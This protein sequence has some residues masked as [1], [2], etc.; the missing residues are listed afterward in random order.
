MSMFLMLYSPPRA[1]IPKKWPPN[2]WQVYH[3]YSG[4][5]FQNLIFLSP[6]NFQGFRVPKSWKVVFLPVP[7]SMPA[8]ADV[9]A[10]PS[11][12]VFRATSCARVVAVERI[13]SS[14]IADLMNVCFIISLLLCLVPFILNLAFVCSWYLFSAANIRGISIV[15]KKIFQKGSIYLCKRLHI[16]AICLRTHII[17]HMIISV[18]CTNMRKGNRFFLKSPRPSLP[19]K[20]APPLTPTLSPSGKREETAPPRRS[21]PLRSKVGGASK[22][23]PY[24]A[25]WD[26]LIIAC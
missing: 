19:L 14:N 25:G 21:E 3:L 18:I 1:W 5:T 2:F 23:S 20:R 16:H 12:L 24:F 10:H 4:I 15:S 7:I 13:S 26:R 9:E 6:E 22:P 8:L 17:K 11:K